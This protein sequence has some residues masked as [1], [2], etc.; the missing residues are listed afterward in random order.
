[1]M[2]VFRA[3]LVIGIW[4]LVITAQAVALPLIEKDEVVSLTD[5]MA[6]ITWTT[7]NENSDTQVYYGIASPTTH[8]TSSESV[9][10]HY[11]V[12]TGLTPGTTY[13]FYVSSGSAEGNQKAF[14]TLTA[15]S[16]Q[17]LFSFATLSDPQYGI[18][19]ADTTGARGRPYSSSEAIL[20][21]TVNM[22]NTFTP[23]F[24]ILKGDL[25][26]SSGGTYGNYMAFTAMPLSGLTIKQEFDTLTKA[27]DISNKYFPIPGNHDKTNS[28]YSSGA[29]PRWYNDNLNQLYPAISPNPT[30]DHCFNYS[31][32][33]R[34]YRF[35][36]LDSVD[37]NLSAEVSTSFLTQE[38]TSAEALGLKCFIFTHHPVTDVRTENL[39]IDVI[40]EVTGGTDDYSKIQI[41]NTAEVQAFIT[42]HKDSIAGIFSGHIHDNHYNE[43]SGVPAVRTASGLQFPTGF[44]IYKV[45]SNGYMQT[46]YKVPYWT[47][48]ARNVITPEAGYSDTYWEQF[49]LGS[50]SAR[51]FV[52]ILSS[53]KP[54]L[55]E[56][57][58]SNSDTNVPVND[59]IIIKFTKAMSQTETQN[60]I[61]FSPDISGKTFTWSG[62]NTVVISH[63]AF[64]PSTSYAV[65]ISGAK[66]STGITMDAYSF[67][68]TTSAQ[69]DTVPPSI[70]FDH[71]LLNI[72]NDNQP[73]FTG[74]ATDE[75]SAITSIEC[76]IDGGSWAAASP[77]DGAFNSKQE[78]FYIKSPSVLV[79]S[80]DPHTIEAR[81]TDSAGNTNSTYESYTFYVVG[82]KPEI[83]VKT[84]GQTIVSGDPTDKTPSF[85]VVVISNKGLTANPL[86]ATIDNGT[87][88]TLTKTFDPNNA[89]ILTSIYNPTLTDGVHSLKISITD[90]QGNPST[91]EVVGLVVQANSDISLQGAP[92]TYPNPYNGTGNVSIGYI[93][94]KNNSIT[95]TIHDLMGSQLVKKSYSSGQAGGKAGYNE[96]SWN[97]KT[98][99]GE[100]LGNGI[101]I[102]LII[103]D[104]KVI[105]RGKLTVAR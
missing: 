75:L 90:D 89:G 36:M 9:K 7:T 2:K 1:M 71:F 91:R 24:T 48:I 72:T 12:L 33:Y 3:F 32:D 61:T 39:P 8:F 56:S 97:G 20:I 21:S 53:A 45:Y 77:I 49:S 85:E 64:S 78:S 15:P 19:K 46:F 104:G 74:I 51:N 79:R 94:S 68:F 66:D 81:G 10:Y 101:Y 31:F 47:E 80:F 87:P 25:I 40:K 43:I 52:H 95:I 102:Y 96:V 34:G 86:Q 59:T 17:Y 42:Q 13:S 6:I 105:S 88:E 16:G 55:S 100:E 73:T 67:A 26:E 44:N 28:A 82:D 84:K 76:R 63:S 27:G 54:S 70:L 92:L 22:I 98:D 4:S 35:I 58:P 57:S 99:A 93:L 23:S 50:N 18:G 37:N 65:S 14:T 60:A 30:A 29:A 69:S 5:T 38:V 41:M 11:A 103:A 83:G 62:T